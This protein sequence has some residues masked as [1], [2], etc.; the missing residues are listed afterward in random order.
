MK[1]VTRFWSLELFFYKKIKIVFVLKQL[2]KLLSKPFFQFIFFPRAKV[3]AA[4][5]KELFNLVSGIKS[6]RW[7]Q[8]YFLNP[9]CLAISIAFAERPPILHMKII[10]VSAEGFFRLKS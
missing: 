1:N 9:S 6:R 2:I 7:T 4:T 10:S 5:K 8:N 3:I